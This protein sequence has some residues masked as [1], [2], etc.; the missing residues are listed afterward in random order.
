L[1]SR[2]EGLRFQDLDHIVCFLNLLGQLSTIQVVLM[3]ALRFIGNA[4]VAQNNVPSSQ[5]L[6]A[7]SFSLVVKVG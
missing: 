1:G 5:N 2:L 7:P 6:E 3:D 4:G